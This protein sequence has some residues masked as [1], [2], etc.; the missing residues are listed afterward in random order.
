MMA[1]LTK[2]P[3]I[4][5]FFTS[6]LPLVSKASHPK[7]SVL[8]VKGVYAASVIIY[9]PSLAPGMCFLPIISLMEIILSAC[10]V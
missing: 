4:K 10:F 5:S 2:G 7:I 6:H 1:K 8:T 3:A 9:I